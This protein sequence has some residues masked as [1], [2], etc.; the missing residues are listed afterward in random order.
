[1]SKLARLVFVSAAALLIIALPVPA[2]AST[3]DAKNTADRVLPSGPSE[4]K[5]IKVAMDGQVYEVEFTEFTADRVAATVTLPSGLQVAYG[6]NWS[7]FN[8]SEVLA[9]GVASG[10]AVAQAVGIAAQ[11]V[12]LNSAPAIQVA[13]MAEVSIDGQSYTVEFVQ[14]DLSGSVFAAVTL[15]SSVEVSYGSQWAGFTPDNVLANAVGHRSVVL[16]AVALAAGGKPPVRAILPV[17]SPVTTDISQPLP[18]LPHAVGG[19]FVQ[20]AAADT[21]DGGAADSESDGDGQLSSGS[22]PSPPAGATAPD[23]SP[24]SPVPGTPPPNSG[25]QSG[26]SPDSNSG[27]ASAPGSGGSASGSTSEPGPSGSSGSSASAGPGGGGNTGGPGPSENSGSS[28][29]SGQGGGG[30]SGR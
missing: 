9:N 1:M 20:D 27:S 24:P 7:G 2:I 29:S 8:A 11:T 18:P 14:L 3:F 23:S 21:P 10:N 28:S 30:L 13:N 4:T 16:Q 15:P 12:Q 19:L 25:T 26:G 22:A 5:E 6:A 17:L